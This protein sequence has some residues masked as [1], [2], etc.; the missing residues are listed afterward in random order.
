M[1]QSV[2]REISSRFEREDRD[3]P[4]SATRIS[5]STNVPVSW[6]PAFALYCS[7]VGKAR[8]GFE[9]RLEQVFFQHFCHSTTSR[10]N[11]K[12]GVDVPYMRVHC[13][14]AYEELFCYLFL[15]MPVNH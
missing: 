11:M 8:E 12:F 6:Y 7:D 5:K 13:E 3:H 9:R 14:I 10:M 1:E 2:T 15:G 4:H